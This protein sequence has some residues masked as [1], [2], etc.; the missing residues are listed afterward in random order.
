VARMFVR[1]LFTLTSNIESFLRQ[2]RRTDLGEVGLTKFNLFLGTSFT[3][4]FYRIIYRS[5]LKLFTF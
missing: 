1:I 3:H 5:L 4:L 2:Y